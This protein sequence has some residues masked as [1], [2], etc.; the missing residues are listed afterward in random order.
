MRRRVLAPLMAVGILAIPDAALAHGVSARTDLPLPLAL[1]TYAAGVVLIV[2]FAA[3]AWLWPQPRWERGIHGRALPA[4]AQAALR[5]I[6]WPLRILGIAL[7]AVVLYAAA[8][9]PDDPERN[10][11]AVTIYV[12][13][14]VGFLFA[15]G[16]IGDL[17]RAIG[18]VWAIGRL[19]ERRRASY[20]FG[21]WPAAIG[22]AAF[23]WLELVHPDPGAK[24]V[25]VGALSIYLVVTFTATLIWGREWLR[26]GDPF[27]ALFGVVAAMAPFYV[28]DEGR[29]RL[30]PPLVGL[31][32][33][34]PVRGT[35]ALV[36]VALGS[37]TYDG[38]SRTQLWTRIIGD[39]NV[40]TGTLGLLWTIGAVYALYRLAISAMPVLAG[41]PKDDRDVDETAMAFVHSLIPIALAYA[42]A[43][44]FSLLV[45]EAQ[46]AFR[47]AS[48][49]F[50]KG[51][52]MFGTVDW[53]ISYTAMSTKA[54]AYIQTAAIVGGHVAGVVLAH[55]RAVSRYP[56]KVATRTQYPL[57]VVMVAYTVGALVIL[58]G[59]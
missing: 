25:L 15:S 12:L 18:P 49:P 7:L 41:V 35:V 13:F 39:G 3:L 51:W 59:G 37:T 11:A 5:A 6:A 27:C 16:V 1:V 44:Y 9:G 43:H 56:V 8:V 50:G 52:D 34:Q 36:V 57:L 20:T 42:V 26:E 4:G 58:L 22:L 54:I 30:R 47:L 21:H 10:I 38:L 2:T 48:D 55:D 28:D 17:W 14:W 40:L 45:F 33:L 53:T 29:L 23:T 31:S 46:A 32:T 19:I 24:R